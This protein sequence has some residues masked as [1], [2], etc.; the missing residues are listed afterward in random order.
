M[1]ED[2]PIVVTGG[3]VSLSFDSNAL[4]RDTNGKYKN[5]NKKIRRVEITGDYDP[6]TGDVSNG[7]VTVTISYDN[8]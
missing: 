2:V 1:P 7:N 8:G 6:A 4:Q 5:A 3:S